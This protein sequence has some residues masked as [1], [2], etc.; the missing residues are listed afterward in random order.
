MGSAVFKDPIRCLIWD[1][2][3]LPTSEDY[4]EIVLWRAFSPENQKG[5]VSIPTLIEA[6]AESLRARYLAWVYQLGEFR[7]NGIRL[8]DHLRVRSGFSYWWLSLIAE[9]C[10]FSKSPHIT[11]AI[12]LFAFSDWADLKALE[13][14]TLVSSSKP[15]ALCLQDWC[16][17]RGIRYNWQR[18]PTRMAEGSL[19]RRTFYRLPPAFRAVVWLFRYCL[20]RWALRGVGLAEWRNSMGTMT[21]VTYLINGD[22]NVASSSCRSQ[23][24]GPLPDILQSEGRRT[25]WLYLYVQSSLL[26]SSK[27]AATIIR[28]LNSSKENSTVHCTLD[29]FLSYEVLWRT[30]IDW[31]RLIW[32]GR[33]LRAT[34]SKSAMAS[35]NLWPLFESD[36]GESTSGV[37]AITNS[38]FNSLFYKALSALK[39]QK[40]CFYLQ[41]NQGW[42]LALL[43][44]WSILNHGSLVGVPHSSVRFWD[45][46]YFSCSRNYYPKGREPRTFPDKIAVNGQAAL[47]TFLASGCPKDRLVKVEA[48]RYLY[49]SD[50]Q[51]KSV[52]TTRK[53]REKIRF[54]VL[55]DYLELNQ[56]KQIE[57]LGSVYDHLST[58]ANI[59]FKAHP[60][61]SFDASRYTTLSLSL[62]VAAVGDLL[63]ECDMVFASPTTSAALEAYCAGVPVISMNDPTILNFSPIRG[64]PNTSFVSSPSELLNAID[65]ALAAGIAKPFPEKFFYLDRSLPR[66]RDLLNTS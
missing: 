55:G 48:L 4:V 47:S 13:S 41:E 27:E 39:K 53:R 61:C 45:L 59:T 56:Y 60:Y 51:T 21:F 18:L 11:D 15:L 37:T 35:I 43:Q 5:F 19:A 33:Q 25:N 65:G 40:V 9:K 22:P 42:E 34:L 8:V 38:L 63:P 58:R 14:L 62:S 23:H 20:A 3:E 24:W 30:L 44:N 6:N 28:S 10:N 54:L 57:L 52:S 16:Q 46:R 2:E 36:M 50:V 26:P 66:W 29:S 1:S 49:L 32:K 31:T 12:R 64:F 17:S 7:I